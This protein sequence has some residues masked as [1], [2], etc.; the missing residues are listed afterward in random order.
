M[1]IKPEHKSTEFNVLNR[2][3][4]RDSFT[5]GDVC[6]TSDDEDSEHDHSIDFAVLTKRPLTD[7][8]VIGS[9]SRIRI[10]WAFIEAWS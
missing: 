10:W 2:K 7:L 3:V 1:F 6:V 5:L 9:N 4:I 8:I